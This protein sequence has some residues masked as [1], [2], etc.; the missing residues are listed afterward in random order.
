MPNTRRQ[1]R[2][3]FVR[4]FQGFVNE[5]GEI[6][7]K[8]IVKHIVDTTG[9]MRIWVPENNPKLNQHTV[10]DNDPLHGC[11]ACFR[12]LWISICHEFGPASGRAIMHKIIVERG[13]SRVYFPTYRDL[14]KWE[15]NEKMR[16][17]YSKCKNVEEIANRWN[18]SWQRAAQIVRG[19]E[20]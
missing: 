6:A 16:A 1:N 19:E 17:Q 20:D 10:L 18:M 13:G 3:T 4:L 14:Y 9:G 15:R 12:M 8:K 7:G 5:Y 11:S 2:E